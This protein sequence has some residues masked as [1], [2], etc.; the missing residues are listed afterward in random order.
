MPPLT[1]EEAMFPGYC[2]FRT[3]RLLLDAHTPARRLMASLAVGRIAFRASCAPS[4]SF[5]PYSGAV[6][7]TLPLKETTP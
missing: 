7:V 3:E 2:L 1:F 5:S 6:L 4:C